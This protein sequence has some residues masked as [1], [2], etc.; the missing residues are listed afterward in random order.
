MAFGG[1]L[2][3]PDFMSTLT[4]SART[5]ADTVSNYAM[6][7][8]LLAGGMSPLLCAGLLLAAAATTAV[9][10]R[11]SDGAFGAWIVVGLLAAPILWS[12][13]LVLTL[14]PLTVLLRGIHEKGSSG[15]LAGWAVLSLF[16][17][18]PAPAVAYASAPF[19][20]LIPSS[21]PVPVIPVVLVLLWAWLLRRQDR[22]V[23]DA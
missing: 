16:V 11:S 6:V 5:Y 23:V 9:G 22:T 20:P 4:F 13:H 17:S 14:V 10:A 8:R 15:A 7:G 12:Q 1:P 18:L 2:I 19:A 3:W 21:H